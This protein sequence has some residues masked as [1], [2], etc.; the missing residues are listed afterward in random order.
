MLQELIKMEK[1]LQKNISYIL[2][3]ID[4]AILMARLSSSLV[5]NLCEGSHRVKG[6]F[7]HCDKNSETFRIKCKYCDWFHEYTYFKDDLIK[8]RCLYCNKNYQHM[9]DENLKERFFIA[10]KFCIFDNNSFILLLHK[11]IYSSE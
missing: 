10:H 9:F 5:N 6:K 11:G 3:F 7:G 2:K 4:S 8:C 1:K